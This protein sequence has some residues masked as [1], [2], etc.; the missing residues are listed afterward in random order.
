M[1]K[2]RRVDDA[3]DNR[4]AELQERFVSEARDKEADVLFLGD[5][6]IALLEQSIIYRENLAPL[7]CLCFGAFGDKISNLSWRLENNILEGLDPKVI[8]VSIGNSDFDLTDEQMLEALKSVA[9]TIR[10]QKPS[11]KLYFMKLLPSGRRPNKRREL[12]NRVNEN[13]EKVLK[14][15]A[16]VIDVEPSIQGTN[17]QIESH[18]MF[19][20]VHLTQE[21]YR[22]IYE[23]VLVA[24]GYVHFGSSLL[25]I[26]IPM[27]ASVILVSARGVRSLNPHHFRP[28]WPIFSKAQG[29]RK[30]GPTIHERYQL[31]GQ[32]DEF[33]ELSPKFKKENPKELHDYTGV[34]DVGFV[35]PITKEFVHVEEMHPELVVPDLRGFRLR[36]YVSYRTDFEIE[37][38][39]KNFE[40]LA[41]KY[42]NEESA[43]SVVFEGEKWPPPKTTPR[44]LFDMH[45][46]PLI[47]QMYNVGE[48]FTDAEVK[49]ETHVD[50]SK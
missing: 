30:R 36:P 44:L 8:V 37:K 34:Q 40:K 41:A 20:Y 31:P 47:R 35:N 13:L 48:Y 3:G 39:R 11:S 49:D 4:W 12:V 22:K 28:P 50:K 17:G 38:K 9:G 27:L 23:P 18:Y 10:K 42:G 6:H 45:Y 26:K 16:D 25:I 32:D 46:A 24:Y 19:D 14:G 29:W 33:P 21:G 2:L 43:D 5:D 1:K 7:H 15:V